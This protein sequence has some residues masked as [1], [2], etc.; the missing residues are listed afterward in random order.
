M[1]FPF[2][3]GITSKENSVFPFAFLICSVIF[4]SLN[5]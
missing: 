4:I 2:F 1:L 3:G 5:P